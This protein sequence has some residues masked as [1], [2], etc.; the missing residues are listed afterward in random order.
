MLF[1]RDL[2]LAETGQLM[3]DVNELTSSYIVRPFIETYFRKDIVVCSWIP[4]I[5]KSSY[6]KET[7]QL[8]CNT[9]SAG[10]C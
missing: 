8:I 4:F 9:N 10:F 6:H 1:D 2:C 3:C 7:R 5:K